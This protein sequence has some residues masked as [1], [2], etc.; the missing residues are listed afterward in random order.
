MASLREAILAAAR[1]A[2]AEENEKEAQQRRA[3]AHVGLDVRVM[4]D[5]M[6]ESASG[7]SVSWATGVLD[8]KDSGLSATARAALE[9]SGDYTPG[10]G[11]HDFAAAAARGDAVADPEAAR[12][13]AVLRGFLETRSRRRS[14]AAAQAAL[15]PEASPEFKLRFVDGYEPS[16]FTPA[17]SAPGAAEGDTDTGGYRMAPVEREWGD[18]HAWGD[19]ETIETVMSRRNHA[20]DLGPSRFLPGVSGMDVPEVYTKHEREQVRA[21]GEQ[22]GEARDGLLRKVEAERQQAERKANM[23]RYALDASERDE[24]VVGQAVGPD[25]FELPADPRAITAAAAAAERARLRGGQDQLLRVDASG[26]VVRESGQGY[27]GADDDWQGLGGTGVK[28]PGH[29]KLLGRA[30]AWESRWK[31]PAK[32][33]ADAAK[34]AAAQRLGESGASASD[35]AVA[36]LEAAHPAWTE[37]PP[38]VGVHGGIEA[39]E[40]ALE[41]LDANRDA[42]LTEAGKAPPKSAR[43]QRARRGGMAPDPKM[44]MAGTRTISEDF[45]AQR[46]VPGAGGGIRVLA[47]ATKAR[48][49]RLGTLGQ[50][51][52]VQRHAL[53]ALPGG[54]V[55]APGAGQA[56][57]AVIEYVEGVPIQKGPPPQLAPF[58]WPRRAQLPIGCRV[59]QVRVGNDHLACRVEG[60]RVRLP[61][62]SSPGGLGAN[63]S[64]TTPAAALPSGS[65]PQP[66]SPSVDHGQAIDR[67][68][69]VSHARG[70]KLYSWVGRYDG[71]VLTMG[72]GKDGQTGHG[73]TRDIHAPDLIESLTSAD[74][75]DVDCGEDH[76][77]VVTAGGDV[78]CFGNGDDHRLGSGGSEGTS[79]P[80]F[81]FWVAQGTH[82]IKAVAAGG[83]HTLLLTEAK[84]LLGLGCNADGQLGIGTKRDA[85]KPTRVTGLTSMRVCAIA[86]GGRHSLVATEAGLLYAFG[87]NDA[88]QLGLGSR[89]DAM[90]E[91]ADREYDSDEEDREELE[92]RVA[93]DLARHDQ[94]MLRVADPDYADDEAPDEGEYREIDCRQ[95]Q[96]A[97]DNAFWEPAAGQTVPRRVRH[98]EWR[99]GQ[100]GTDSYVTESAAAAASVAA[101]AGD[102]GHAV[103]SLAAGEMHSIVL[104]SGGAVYTFGAGDRGQL[105]HGDAQDRHWPCCVERLTGAKGGQRVL[106]EQVAAGAAHSVALSKLGLVYTWGAGEVAQLGNGALEDI[107]QPEVVTA[108]STVR[109]RQVAA[110]G[111]ATAFVLRH[112]GSLW[113]AGSAAYGRPGERNPT[114]L[115]LLMRKVLEKRDQKK[116]LVM[117]STIDMLTPHEV[118]FSDLERQTILYGPFNEPVLGH[119]L[120][121]LLG[122]LLA[123]HSFLHMLVRFLR[124]VADHCLGISKYAFRR[125][126]VDAIEHAGVWLLKEQHD[127]LDLIRERQAN[128]SKQNSPADDNSSADGGPAGASTPVPTLGLGGMSATPPMTYF[129]H[130]HDRV[131]LERYTRWRSRC[132]VLGRFVKEVAASHL[133]DESDLADVEAACPGSM[134][135]MHMLD[136]ALAQQKL[137]LFRQLVQQAGGALAAQGGDDDGTKKGNA[138]KKSAS[139]LA[140]TRVYTRASEDAAFS[141]HVPGLQGSVEGI[142]A[143]ES[144]ASHLHRRTEEREGLI[145]LRG[146]PSLAAERAE[147]DVREAMERQAAETAARDAQLAALDRASSDVRFVGADAVIRPGGFREGAPENKL[148]AAQQ[149]QQSLNHLARRQPGQVLPPSL[150]PRLPL[151]ERPRTST[152]SAVAAP[153]N[154]AV[155]ESRERR[156]GSQS[157]LAPPALTSVAEGD[158]ALAL[159]LAGGPVGDSPLEDPTQIVPALA[160]RHTPPTVASERDE[161][162]AQCQRMRMI[163]ERYA[164]PPPAPR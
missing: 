105:G 33:V 104:T 24:V 43:R 51:H 37:Q 47:K 75:R 84:N 56:D 131:S 140:G 1:A 126:L 59:V 38:G 109:V 7:S 116:V 94:E 74:V 102:A 62:S 155:D 71:L 96:V 88:G 145:G 133:I 147:K 153:L 61:K 63:A 66:S 70:A 111:G 141:G 19:Q 86:C 46:F 4:D 121:A 139:L 57:G 99:G 138:Q 2:K 159:G 49:P 41:A 93:A 8:S 127:D 146:V 136:S 135:S 150:L 76:T 148:V 52:L 157:S 30:G 69:G 89:G 5:S 106:I 26:D 92:R 40:A 36:L 158:E 134:H 108:L 29:D 60:E 50:H 156:H 118:R 32:Q 81:L 103:V 16:G 129:G 164:D 82:R 42:A 87:N 15:Q 48:F 58:M 119:L 151:V 45:R 23:A 149:Q 137:D 83:A 14:L 132:R 113:T 22:R 110:G 154:A 13:N 6:E 55:A 11:S 3:P 143:V 120:D 68:V 31:S 44:S 101:A 73:N 144:W 97:D 78:A 161:F 67:Q 124:S 107:F 77:A 123:H 28:T 162:F 90:V 100:S 80:R 128:L 130:V 9:A 72:S 112:D 142:A 163:A 12:Q 152:L 85:L 18:S 79:V 95:Q 53:I 21:L 64:P 27:A 54:S 35:A 115:A 98:P 125:L 117:C 65:S 34:D 91:R 25:D 160:V 20:V 122:K 17:A 39:V 114:R 10:A